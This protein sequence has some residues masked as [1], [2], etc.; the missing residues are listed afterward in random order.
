MLKKFI[1]YYK[2]HWRLFAADMICAVM[3]AAVD[4]L[5]PILSRYAMQNLLPD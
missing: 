5:F 2:P 3:I 1:S 4:L